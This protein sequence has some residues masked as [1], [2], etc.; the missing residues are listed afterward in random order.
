MSVQP[1]IVIFATCCTK[2]V[3]SAVLPMLRTT[4]QH[5]LCSMS[6]VILCLLCLMVVATVSYRKGIQ[7]YVVTTAGSFVSDEST[8][9]EARTRTC[10][11]LPAITEHNKYSDLPASDLPEWFQ[12]KLRLNS[13]QSGIF[14]FP[15]VFES[16]E[17]GLLTRLSLTTDFALQVQ[18]SYDGNS[19]NYGLTNSIFERYCQSSRVSSHAVDSSITTTSVSK[20]TITFST[21]HLLADSEAMRDT[22]T[23]RSEHSKQN[24]VPIDAEMYKLTIATDG[25]VHITVH[26]SATHPSDST[27]SSTTTAFAHKGVANAL[28]T[29]DQLLHQTVPLRLPL[30]VL[31][32]PDNAWR[33]TTCVF[34]TFFYV[35]L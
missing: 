7:E 10:K 32:W 1:L 8:T 20:I 24:A 25:T 18:H 31:D 33:G 6:N 23:H 13:S 11:A 34:V 4:N 21:E 17:D 12:L 35:L 16:A 26:A 9:R 28:A 19:S 15:K 5:G 2:F 27:T 14:P 22:L 29:L 30:R 3:F